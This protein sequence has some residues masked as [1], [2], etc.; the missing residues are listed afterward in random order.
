MEELLRSVQD[1]ETSALNQER[2]LTDNLRKELRQQEK[3]HKDLAEKYFE[4]R[5]NL[6]DDF[7]AARD[8]H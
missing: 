7:Q 5:K 1:Q 2:E 4:T 8:E 6:K 3:R